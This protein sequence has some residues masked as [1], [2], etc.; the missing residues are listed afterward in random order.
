MLRPPR[1]SRLRPDRYLWHDG[2]G[3]FVRTL[4]VEPDGT[5]TPDMAIDAACQVCISSACSMSQ[6]R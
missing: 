3:R 5:L 1:R 2:R 4:Y 6:D